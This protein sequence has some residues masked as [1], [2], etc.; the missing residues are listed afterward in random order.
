M[1]PRLELPKGVPVALRELLERRPPLPLRADVLPLV[2]ADGAARGRVD[3][4]G[5]LGS[6]GEAEKVRHGSS[7]LFK[8]RLYLRRRR[9]CAKGISTGSSSASA[10]ATSSAS[11]MGRV[12][13][14]P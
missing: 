12:R 14:T 4:F 10:A 11:E 13:K 6:A 5:E 1:E 3:R 9:R 8:L 7:L 2:L